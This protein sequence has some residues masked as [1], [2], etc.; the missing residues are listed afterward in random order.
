M[1]RLGIAF[2]PNLDMP[3]SA[4]EESMFWKPFLC[5]IHKKIAS[6]KLKGYIILFNIFKVL[7]N[8]CSVQNIKR[9]GYL[10]INE[11]EIYIYLCKMLSLFSRKAR[12][13]EFPPSTGK[14]RFRTI[15]A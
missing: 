11:L 1:I 13:L 15:L 7:N 9:E 3:F 8:I 5:Y 2:L 14:T 6:S 10:Q 4:K 12:K